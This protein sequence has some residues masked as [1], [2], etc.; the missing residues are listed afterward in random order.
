MST[1]CN[2]TSVIDKSESFHNQQVISQ[3]SK[4]AMNVKKHIL[5]L[6]LFYI[7]SL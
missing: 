6:L 4:Q 2:N 7:W 5:L 1:L 3:S